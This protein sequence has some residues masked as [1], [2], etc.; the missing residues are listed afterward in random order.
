MHPHGTHV[1]MHTSMSRLMTATFS[2]YILAC[3][4]VLPSKYYQVVLTI[5]YYY[6]P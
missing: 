4:L 1:F 5:N 3:R 6:L 2:L